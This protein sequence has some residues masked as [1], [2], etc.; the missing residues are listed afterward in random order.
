[1]LTFAEIEIPWRASRFKSGKKHCYTINY[2]NIEETFHPD[3]LEILKYLLNVSSLQVECT[4]TVSGTTDWQCHN[5]S[6][7]KDLKTRNL[8]KQ[9]VT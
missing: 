6:S 8:V 7:T 9:E 3:F 4:Q 1:M 5:I 2:N